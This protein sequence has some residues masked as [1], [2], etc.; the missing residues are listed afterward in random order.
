MAATTLSNVIDVEIFRELPALDS[1]ET[2]SFWQSGVITASPLYDEIA[3]SHGAGFEMPFWGDLS[4]AVQPNLSN[5]DPTDFAVPNSII[6]QDL[7]GRK[8]FLNVGWGAADLVRE[9]AA[10]GDV[11]QRIR[12]R[13]EAWWAQKFEDRVVSSAIGVLRNNIANDSSDMVIDISADAADPVAAANLFNINAYTDAV[14]TMGERFDSLSTV[15]MHPIVASNVS[16]A[17]DIEFIRDSE[18]Q[19]L[20]RTYKGAR[21]VVSDQAP[22]YQENGKT[23]YVTML[24][25]RAAFAFGEGDP[26]V[27]YALERN[28]AQGNGGGFETLWTRK[29]WILQPAGHSQ[30]IVTTAPRNPTQVT[31]GTFTQVELEDPRIWTR[32]YDRRLVQMA[33]II[34]NG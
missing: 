23:H 1:P 8:A 11:M 22:A 27:P 15:V 6:Q 17:D 19:V 30:E 4:R 33:F 14:F 24:F 20:Y 32:V 2:T 3:R 10:G 16:K 12:N 25:G 21:L 5:D 29:T 34:S 26:A 31:P 9:V 7:K 13:I 28:E 18:G